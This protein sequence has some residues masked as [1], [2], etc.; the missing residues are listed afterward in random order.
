MSTVVIA[1]ILSAAV[2]AVLF[3][4]V[5]TIDR[6]NHS[7]ELVHARLDQMSARLTEV[8]ASVDALVAHGATAALDARAG[9]LIERST[10]K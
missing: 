8:V 2:F 9:Q 6:L 1:W 3:S 5:K 4:L 7:I 10:G